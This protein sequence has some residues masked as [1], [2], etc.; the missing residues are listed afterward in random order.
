[1]FI[2]TTLEL[3]ALLKLQKT[4]FSVALSMKLSSRRKSNPE[5]SN[6]SDTYEQTPIELK[7][8]IFNLIFFVS[9]KSLKQRNTLEFATTTIAACSTLKNPG[10]AIKPA[11][12]ADKQ[13]PKIQFK[14]QKTKFRSGLILLNLSWKNDSDL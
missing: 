4:A 6:E 10:V 11:K 1:M 3:E 5:C 7:R 12:R 13:R 14:P 8:D 2:R 9:S